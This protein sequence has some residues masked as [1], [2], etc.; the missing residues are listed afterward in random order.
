MRELSETSYGREL[1]ALHCQPKLDV[2]CHRFFESFCQLF[3][4]LVK[5]V[6][7][8]QKFDP[9][10][11]KAFSVMHETF[12]YME[13]ETKLMDSSPNHVDNVITISSLGDW[14]DELRAILADASAPDDGERTAKTLRSIE[15]V[16]SQVP[17]LCVVCPGLKTDLEKWV[18]SSP[19]LDTAALTERLV[20]NLKP[21]GDKLFIPV[22]DT[23]R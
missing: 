18:A 7:D 6:L 9:V 22:Q 13:G 20:N 3:E 2:F 21:E 11:C 10:T 16:T 5:P 4:E 8:T 12:K 14:W 19:L 23:P 1:L 17:A 15:H